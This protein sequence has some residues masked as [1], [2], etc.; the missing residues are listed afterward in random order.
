MEAFSPTSGIRQGG[1]LSP[2]I[3]VLC[4]ECLTYLIDCEVKLGE[5]K[6][7]RESRNAPP[8]ISNLTFVDDLILFCEASTQQA[9]VMKRCLQAFCDASGYKV[10]LAKSRI[11][12][13]IRD[14]VSSCLEMETTKEFGNYLGVPTINERTSKREY[15]FLV[16]KLV[17]RQRRCL[18][19]GK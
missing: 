2:Y 19:R 6:V 9:E 17:G 12:L 11:N 8:P 13:D 5:K 18:L 4:M 16:D 15:Q 14:A 3:Y 10:S 1:L 7:V